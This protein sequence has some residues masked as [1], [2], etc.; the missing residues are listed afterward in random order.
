[1]TDN[2]VE[3][4]RGLFHEYCCSYV[5]G[6]DHF[7]RKQEEVMGRLQDDV[8]PG[9][10]PTH[11]GMS[12]NRMFYEGIYLFWY[13]ASHVA[14][15]LDISGVMAVTTPS[16]YMKLWYGVRMMSF[17]L[18]KKFDPVLEKALPHTEEDMIIK[19]RQ[20]LRKIF[21]AL[22]AYICRDF[23]KYVENDRIPRAEFIRKTYGY[24]EEYVSTRVPA[25]P[26]RPA[27]TAIADLLD[28]LVSTILIENMDCRKLN[29]PLTFPEEG[30]GGAFAG[31]LCI[32]NLLDPVYR[33]IW[34]ME[35]ALKIKFINNIL[36]SSVW[37][38]TLLPDSALRKRKPVNLQEE[39]E[40]AIEEV[41]GEDAVQA[42]RRG[43]W[44]MIDY[45]A[46]AR[47]LDTQQTPQTSSKDEE[48]SPP[49]KSP[50]K[51]GRPEL[52]D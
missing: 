8:Q 41:C 14:T 24:D 15:M 45:Q 21:G 32:G 36:A 20:R 37:Y 12:G 16:L 3:I 4:F 39:L 48:L 22:N 6:R 34:I 40:K 28:G 49:R 9:T 11:K 38:R 1:M 2:V 42:E 26:F 31:A 52:N 5:S 23:S 25:V 10:W 17:F 7:F 50:L 13:L 19:M 30:I 47:E 35:V 44:R 29:K 27:Q 18:D 51:P 46:E 33:Q 43:P